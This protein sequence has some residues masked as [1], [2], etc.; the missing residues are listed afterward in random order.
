MC[1]RDR[2]WLGRAHNM[3]GS[4]FQQAGTPEDCRGLVTCCRQLALLGQLTGSPAEAWNWYRQALSLLEPLA[5]E[6]CV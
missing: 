5:R 6:R 4:L 3:W 2:D 1:I